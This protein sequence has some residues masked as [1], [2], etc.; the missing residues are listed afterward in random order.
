M[1]RKAKSVSR[2]AEHVP[3]VLLLGPCIEVWADND[4]RSPSTEH[5]AAR[6]NFARVRRGWFESINLTDATQQFQLVPLGAPFS[7]SYLLEDGRAE[8]MVKRFAAA[9]SDLE[10]LPQLRNEALQLMAA[11]NVAQIT[12]RTA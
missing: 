1:R 10:D 3:T 6:R 8:Y 5:I 7:V 2:G 9:G 11:F 4:K 12:R